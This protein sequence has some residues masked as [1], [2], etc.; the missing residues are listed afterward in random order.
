MTTDIDLT[1]D[2]FQIVL[3]VLGNGAKRGQATRS[4]S[5]HLSRAYLK[6]KRA[7][8]CHTCWEKLAIREYEPG[9]PLCAHCCENAAAFDRRHESLPEKFIRW[10]LESRAPTYD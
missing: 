10:V 9:V 7:L 1:A 4:S 8:I 6:L 2:E 3:A 5:E